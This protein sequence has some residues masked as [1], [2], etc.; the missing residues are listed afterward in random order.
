MAYLPRR[1]TPASQD[2]PPHRWRHRCPENFHARVHPP[3]P[4]Q[5]QG[6]AAQRLAALAQAQAG[7]EVLEAEV[8]LAQLEGSSPPP[9]KGMEA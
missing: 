8:L 1:P 2:P 9:A 6:P 3:R 4:D 7:D 5:E